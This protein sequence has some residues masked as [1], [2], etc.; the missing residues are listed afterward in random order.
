MLFIFMTDILPY[1]ILDDNLKQFFLN[2]LSF[3]TRL[4]D[5]KQISEIISLFHF[6]CID[7]LKQSINPLL[8]LF[9]SQASRSLGVKASNG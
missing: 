8:S 7:T 4:S 1:Q 3:I 2:K 5:E 6:P 9:H